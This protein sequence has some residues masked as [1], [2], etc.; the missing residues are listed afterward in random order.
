MLSRKLLPTQLNTH[1]HTDMC[2]HMYAHTDTHTHTHTGT[3]T[4]MHAHTHTITL[5]KVNFLYGSVC[6]GVL[7]RYWFSSA[8]TDAE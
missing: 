7:R 3:H 1:A 2:A 4:N 6:N 5:L 8:V